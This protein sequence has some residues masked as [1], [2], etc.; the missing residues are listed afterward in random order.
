MALTGRIKMHSQFRMK[1]QNGFTLI[2]L[3]VTLAIASLIMTAVYSAYVVQQKTYISQGDVTEMQQNIRASVLMLEKDIRMAG[4]DPSGDAGAGFVNNVSFTNGGSLSEI[5]DTNATQISF[6]ADL[7][8]DGEIDETAEDVNGDGNKDISE[9]EQI[10]YRLHGTDLQRYSTTT[11]VV[12]WQT[13]AENIQQMEFNYIMADGSSATVPLSLSNIRCVQVSVLAR[14]G[15]GDRDYTNSQFYCP[16]SN[17]YDAATQDCT[18]AAGT[19][20]GPYNDNLRRRLLI[21]TVKCRNM[22][23]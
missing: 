15:H 2:E 19:K 7:D 13:I 11:G 6:T 23:L 21:I 4:Y 18:N 5:V 8:D 9:I 1:R 17:P 10:S 12:E 3:V 20:W 22:G 16:A 14:A